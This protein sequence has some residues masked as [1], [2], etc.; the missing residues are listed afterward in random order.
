MASQTSATDDHECDSPPVGAPDD[1]DQS[2]VGL[3]KI[4]Y[5]LYSADTSQNA[6]IGDILAKIVL[7]EDEEIKRSSSGCA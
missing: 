1:R 4:V 2:A 3:R 7:T 6:A 5:A